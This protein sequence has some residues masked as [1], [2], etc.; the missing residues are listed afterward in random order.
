M[1][2]H[3]HTDMDRT[4]NGW[5]VFDPSLPILTYEYSFGPGTATAL[6]VGGE[7]G[8]IV[9]S[10]PCRVGA[11]VL[12]DLSRYGA[13]RALIAPN[14]F[15]Y[16][17]LAQWCERFPD[18]PVFAPA[19]AIER[20]RRRTGLSGIRPLSEA[21][22]I[23][24]SRIDLVDMPHY[25]TGEALVRVM[26]GRGL[27]WF[28]TDVV[29]NLPVLPGHPVAKWLFKLSGSAP[30]LKFNNLASLVMVQ[31][32]KALK[33]WLAA[34]IAAAPPAWLIPSHGDVMELAA[35]REALGRLFAAS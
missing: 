15:H 30:G 23:A 24:G 11:G 21:V 9:V 4:P 10:P 25:K 33:R 1:D 12:D 26:S 18:V 29:V 35:G 2:N 6:A 20:L 22:S 32:K 16:M 28:V 14:G 13:V 5:N 27:V 34:Q 19:Q 17:G 7:G 31:D 3:R 8:L